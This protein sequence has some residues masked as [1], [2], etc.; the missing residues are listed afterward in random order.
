MLL[1]PAR[2]DIVAPEAR[3]AAR[4]LASS[5]RRRKEFFF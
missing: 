5:S 3:E 2:H 4:I 1:A